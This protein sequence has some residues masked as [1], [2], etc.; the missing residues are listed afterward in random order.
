MYLLLRHLGANRRIA[1]F[2]AAVLGFNPFYLLLSH[3][4]MTDVPFL[5]TMIVSILLLLRGVNLGRDHELIAG[6]ALACL[7]TFIRQL[8]L[9]ILIGFLFAYPIR[10]G[11]GKRW[12]LMSVMPMILSV[13][14]VWSFERYLDRI[15]QV[16]GLLS[17]KSEGLKAFWT[18][19]AHG[20]TG[21]FKTSLRISFLFLMYL[22]LCSLPFL[23]MIAPRAL[24]RLTFSRRRAAWL[25]VAGVTAG[26]T[27]LLTLR[28]WLMPMIGNHLADFG[29]GV[30]TLPGGRPELPR[31]FW[32]GITALAAMGAAMMILV[33]GV[34][35]REKWLARGTTSRRES[36]PWQAV[37][38]LMVGVFNFGPI[39]SAYIPVFDRYF[40][41]FLPL[42]LG[43]IVALCHGPDLSPGPLVGWLSASV[44]AVYLVFGVAATH[45]YLAWNR[46]RWAAATE[47]HE[48][49]GIPKEEIDGGFEYNNLIDSRERL[50]TR[51]VHRPGS[52][53]VIQDPSRPYR[54]ALEPLPAH[55][56]P[57]ATSS[58]NRGSPEACAASTPCVGPRP[59]RQRHR[60]NPPPRIESD[61]PLGGRSFGF[62]QHEDL[63]GGQGEPGRKRKT[64]KD[65]VPGQ[66]AHSDQIPSVEMSAEKKS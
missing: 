49:S 7:A 12:A 55:E 28:G 5:A 26:V 40:L 18:D 31:P 61:L 35:A 48:R 1:T 10:C 27:A 59:G 2:G 13:A 44:M 63:A 50:R 65:L 42:L 21:V 60:R 38:L 16:P 30:T 23:L 25:L 54:L 4:F 36:W 3:S 37:F 24:A 11:F 19:L 51:W 52:V 39:A 22:G 56:M 64:S 8:G 20:H 58:V 46:A 45:D 17:A 29:M 62:P 41:V 33:L 6:L 32:I 15:G 34:L 43:L 53:E 47:L 66:W 9:M 57:S 14:L